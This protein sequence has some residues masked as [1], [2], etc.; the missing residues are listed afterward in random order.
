MLNY[1]FVNSGV[2]VIP[3]EQVVYTLKSLPDNIDPGGGLF[4]NGVKLV[5]DSTFTQQDI[6]DGLITFVHNDTENFI[7]SFDYSVSYGGE[8][9]INDTFSIDVNPVNDTPTIGQGSSVTLKEGEVTT[10]T[11]SQLSLNDVDG[12]GSDKSTGF[13]T[14]NNLEFQVTALPT[15]GTLF[16]DA[17]NNGIIDVG[18]EITTTQWITKQDLIDG[19]VKYLHDGTENFIDQFTVRARD[20][21]NRP[22]GQPDSSIS[23]TADINIDVFPV[24]DTPIVPLTSSINPANDIIIP[25]PFPGEV[26]T[27]TNKGLGFITPLN[28]GDTGLIDN[29]LLQAID[30]DNNRIQRQYRLSQ[31]VQNGT[32]LLDGKVLGVGSTFT[33]KDIDDGKLSYKHNGSENFTDFF[34]FT[35][36]DGNKTTQVAQFNIQVNPL[37]DKATLATATTTFNLDSTSPLPITGI[38]LADV[39]LVNV[40]VGE[41]D[42]IRVTIDPKLTQAFNGQNSGDTFNAGT[43]NLVTTNNITFIQGT[44]NT[45]GN[46]L[47]IEGTLADINNALA[48]LTYQT[49]TDLN[50][51]IALN[52][53]VDDRLYDGSGNVIGANGGLLNQGTN[54][55]TSPLDDSNNTVTRII[56]I[57]VSTANDNTI[58]NVP[59]N[60]TVTED[61]AS[62]AI[63]SGIEVRDPDTFQTTNNTVQLTVTNGTLSFNNPPSGFTITGN[64]TDTITITGTFEPIAIDALF[65]A[66]GYT[67]DVNFNG[68]DTLEIQA[69]GQGSVGQGG[70]NIA[71]ADIPINVTPVNDVPTLAVPGAQNITSNSPLV[72][73]T[74]NGNVITIDDLAD[75][76]NNGVDNFT[77]TLTAGSG[78]LALSGSSTLTDTDGNA[79]IITITGTK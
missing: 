14:I 65:N 62:G 10:I 33:Q 56:N 44:N 37:N 20:D 24:N 30:S 2:T 38:S 22:E 46:K 61:V 58:L 32:L 53:T 64:G 47:V 34:R 35:I 25:D 78:T 42:R 26:A 11:S 4:K 12:V 1:K 23:G 59:A 51:T 19:K 76:N 77:V 63:F 15:R 31:A 54:G 5:V 21:Q 70:S 69:L 74:T 73:N 75:L 55:G 39:D 66:L 45:L 13:A 52:V 6:N 72:F 16:L 3:N 41:T 27:A 17:N 50:Q 71:I 43:L 57:N 36:S 29:S 67:G 40:A 68:I 7:S 9:R 28:E 8:V 49:N 79:A 18:E 48:S 60:V